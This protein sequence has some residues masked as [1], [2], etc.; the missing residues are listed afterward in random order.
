MLRWG[1]YFGVC[2]AQTLRVFGAYICAHFSRIGGD[3]QRAGVWVD[4]LKSVKETVN[5]ALVC[6]SDGPHLWD[7]GLIS[8]WENEKMGTE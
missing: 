4:T 8:G 5:H 2:F 7:M 1:N 6:G 3:T